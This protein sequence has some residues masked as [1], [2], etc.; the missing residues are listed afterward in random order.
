MYSGVRNEVQGSVPLA[1]DVFQP[2]RHSLEDMHPESPTLRRCYHRHMR[3]ETVSVSPV[4]PRKVASLNYLPRRVVDQGPLQQR[5][6]GEVKAE[7]GGVTVS[8]E[9]MEV[10]R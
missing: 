4:Q 7:D 3:P 9:E 2:G 10:I 8:K 6:T 5:A 1:P